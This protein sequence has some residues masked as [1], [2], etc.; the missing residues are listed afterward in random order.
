MIIS[1]T[2]WGCQGWSA[3]TDNMGTKS[4][5]HLSAKS[6][7]SL[8]RTLNTLWFVDSGHPRFFLFPLAYYVWRLDWMPNYLEDCERTSWP[9]PGFSFP[10][11]PVWNHAVILRHNLLLER[12][13]ILDT[14]SC[15]Y[16]IFGSHSYFSASKVAWVAPQTRESNRHTEELSEEKIL[17]EGILSALVFAFRH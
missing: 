10:L 14:F 11:P 16:A 15:R 17:W 1:L 6:S 7:L 2:L 13:K 3:G 4:G 9:D 12:H 5:S 8:S